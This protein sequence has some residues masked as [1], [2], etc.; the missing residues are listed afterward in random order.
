MK[1]SIEVLQ[2]KEF[3]ES[4]D[5]Q[6]KL[7]TCVS[8]FR[9]FGCDRTLAI[10]I[11]ECAAIGGDTNDILRVLF[12]K[13]PNALTEKREIVEEIGKALINPR[14]AEAISSIA[15]KVDGRCGIVAYTQ[16]F[17]PK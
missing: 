4:V 8:L 1:R 9:R 2:N 6:K 10:D 15:S 7:R 12:E 5:R 16:K 11:D 13:Y 3:I 17:K 14:M